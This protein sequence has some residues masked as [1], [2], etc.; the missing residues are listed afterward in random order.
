MKRIIFLALTFS[1]FLISCKKTEFSEKRNESAYSSAKAFGEISDTDTWPGVFDPNVILNLHLRMTKEDWDVVRFDTSNTIEK[2]AWFKADGEEEILVAVRRKSSRAL[3]S[4]ADPWK[5]GLKISVTRFNSAQR[6]HGLTKLS[7]ENGADV[8]PVAEGVAWNLH[9]F[10]SAEGFYGVETHPGLAAWVN[11]A[12]TT[13]SATPVEGEEPVTTPLGVYVN[14]EQRDKQMMIN[15]NVYVSGASWLYEVDD[16]M[17]YSIEVGDPHSP[18]YN[19]LNF[20]PFRQVSQKVGKKTVIVPTPSD[21]QLK[22]MLDSL[23]DMQAMLTEGA[24]DAFSSNP[25]ALFSHGKNFKF[26]DFSDPLWARVYLPWDLDAVFGKVDYGI[27]GQVGARNKVTQTDYQR[28]I[29]N[30]PYYREQ[31]NATMLALLNGPLHP[32]LLGQH[33]DAWKAVVQPF[34]DQ[35][36]YEAG[37][38]HAGFDDLKPWFVNRNTQVRNQVQKNSPA[39]RAKY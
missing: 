23:I 3:P 28:V 2:Q 35:D 24:I 30:H 6:W 27:Y 8:G 20:I 33:M 18:T 37:S 36:L 10:A 22:G 11:L 21:P 25:D 12:V 5:V 31:Y 7:L 1:L 13:L 16:V 14:V 17:L 15:R 9:E 32:T 19:T 39:P 4:E 26:M 34:L 29:L 38:S